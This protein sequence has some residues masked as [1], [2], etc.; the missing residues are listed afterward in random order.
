MTIRRAGEACFAIRGGEC[1][2]EELLVTVAAEAEASGV[3]D[4]IFGLEV[5][6]D[7]LALA[8]HE[9]DASS[10]A[11]G[12]KEHARTVVVANDHSHFGGRIV[13][14]DDTLHGQGV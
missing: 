5:E 2:G 13:Y 8:E 6:D 14:L 3:I 11:S 1:Q 12:P 10:E 9:E 4:T 7:P